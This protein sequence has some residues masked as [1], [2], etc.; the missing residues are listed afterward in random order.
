[1]VDGDG[2]ASKVT[3]LPRVVWGTLGARKQA[4][5]SWQFLVIRRGADRTGFSGVLD[6]ALAALA[7]LGVAT[8][9]VGRWAAL[10]ALAAL[11]VATTRVGRWAALTALG[12]ATTRLGR[13]ATL[14]ASGVATARLGR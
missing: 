14:T 12:V 11:G 6:L 2:C 7:A 8:T 13:W 10:A 5:K 4:D 3:E 9:R 1:M